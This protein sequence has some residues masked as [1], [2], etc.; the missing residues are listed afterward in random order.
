MVIWMSANDEDAIRIDVFL[1]FYRLRRSKTP[2]YY[3]FLY[4]YRLEVVENLRILRSI[5]T[6]CVI[7]M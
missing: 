3:E 5:L 4:L 7:T 1:F 6:S 2:G